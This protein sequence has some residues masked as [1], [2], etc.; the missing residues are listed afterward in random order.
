MQL[1]VTQAGPAVVVSVAGEIDMLTAPALADALNT[2]FDD[3]QPG[4]PVVL[5]LSRVSFLDS[6]GL[7]VLVQ[8]ASAP[9]A[10]TAGR[11]R[12]VV[13]DARAAIRPLQITGLDKLLPLHRTV[14]DALADAW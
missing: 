14:D 4:A 5:D 1:A 11:L 2:A 13:G 3:T 9:T 6:H 8:A 12:V 7:T 10:S